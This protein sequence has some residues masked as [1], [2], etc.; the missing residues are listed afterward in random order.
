[1]LRCC[2]GSLQDMTAMTQHAAS[3]YAVDL[4]E[5]VLAHAGIVQTLH[6]NRNSSCIMTRT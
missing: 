2:W 4:V 1:M 3:E 6:H 5:L